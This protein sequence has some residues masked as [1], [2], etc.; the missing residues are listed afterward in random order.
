MIRLEGGTFLSDV[1]SQGDSV[2]AVTAWSVLQDGVPKSLSF[3]THVLNQN[4][5]IVGQQDGLGYPPHSW[6][7]GDRFVQKHHVALNSDLPPGQYWLQF[8]LYWRETDQRWVAVRP[9]AVRLRL[10]EQPPAAADA[11]D[12]EERPARASFVG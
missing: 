1:V 5:E 12:P 4:G 7:E 2:T 11:P 9:G 3:F 10:R 6:K 8:G